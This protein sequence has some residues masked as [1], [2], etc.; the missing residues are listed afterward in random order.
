MKRL[1][2]RPGD[3]GDRHEDDA[4]A[5]RRDERGHAICEAP[6]ENG[7]HKALALVEVAVDVFDLDRRVVHQDATASAMRPSVITFNVSLAPRGR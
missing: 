2:A 6:V 1:L 7:L 3:E 4:D 5:E